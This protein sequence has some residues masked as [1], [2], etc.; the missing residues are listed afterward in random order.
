MTQNDMRKA[1]IFLRYSAVH[2]CLVW[3]LEQVLLEMF[4]STSA[5]SLPAWSIFMQEMRLLWYK[6]TSSSSSVLHQPTSLSCSEQTWSSQLSTCLPSSFPQTRTSRFSL[7]TYRHPSMVA[8]T[9]FN[10]LH[11]AICSILHS[12]ALLTDQSFKAFHPPT[13]YLVIWL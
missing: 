1:A 11:L 8:N 2:Q 9:P 12:R 13:L 4:E 10:R 3:T 5:F 6:S 7:R